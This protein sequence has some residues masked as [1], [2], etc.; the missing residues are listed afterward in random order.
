MDLTQIPVELWISQGIFCLLFVWLFADTRKESK[1]RELRLS[2][3]IDKQNEAQEKIV[4]SLENL[5]RQISHLKED[6]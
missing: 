4:K 6:K 1:E 3:Q 5:E 2:Q